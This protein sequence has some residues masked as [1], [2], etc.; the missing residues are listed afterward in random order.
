MPPG[1]PH[2]VFT[3]EDCLAVGGHFW[4][5]AHLGCTLEVLKIQETNPAISNEDISP[6]LYDMLGEVIQECDLVMNDVEIADVYSSVSRFV[7]DIGDLSDSDL[8][9]RL[10]LLAIEHSGLKRKELIR[11]LESQPSSKFSRIVKQ[12]RSEN[13]KLIE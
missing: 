5:A 8:K 4:T 6:K 2:A 9:S 3:P 10:E 1:C 11:L 12:F 7:S 13:Q